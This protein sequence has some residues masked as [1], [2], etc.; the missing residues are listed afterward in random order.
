[1][2]FSCYQLGMPSFFLGERN[3]TNINLQVMLALESLMMVLMYF[4][5][6]VTVQSYFQFCDQFNAIYLRSLCWTYLSIVAI[7]V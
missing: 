7:S 3:K 4:P 1:M 2:L 5:V 6:L